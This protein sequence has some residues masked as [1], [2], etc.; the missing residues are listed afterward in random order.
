MKAL[1]IILNYVAFKENNENVVK[2]PTL[3]LKTK[4][5]HVNSQNFKP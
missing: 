2:N 1:M 4:P 5:Y 3:N